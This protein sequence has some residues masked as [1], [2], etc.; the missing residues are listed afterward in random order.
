MP[1]ALERKLRAEAAERGYGEDRAD[2]YVYGTLRKTGWKPDAEKDDSARHRARREAKALARAKRKDED[3]DEGFV[4]K[5]KRG[6]RELGGLA[7]IATTGGRRGK[8]MFLEGIE[9]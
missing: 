2:A 1:K 3:D 9:R 6:L 5:A 7:M 4:S 8:K